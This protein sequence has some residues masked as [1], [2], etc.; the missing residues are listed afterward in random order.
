MTADDLARLLCREN[1]P[2]LRTTGAKV[3][4]GPCITDAHRFHELTRPAM[5]RTLD[6]LTVVS[7]MGVDAPR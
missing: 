3:P 7:A 4:C 5:R 2:A 1:H 6:V